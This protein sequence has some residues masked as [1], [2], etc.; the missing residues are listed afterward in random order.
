MAAC[1]EADPIKCEC[2]CVRDHEDD[3]VSSVTTDIVIEALRPSWPLVR[4]EINLPGWFII[5]A[6]VIV[7]L[8]NTYPA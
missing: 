2:D 4:V 1:A 7:G 3:D 8:R 5:M 6:A